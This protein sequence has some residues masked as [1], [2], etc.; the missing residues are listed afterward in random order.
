MSSIAISLAFAAKAAMAMVLYPL[1]KKPLQKVTDKL[2]KL[3]HHTSEEQIEEIYKAQRK[4][5]VVSEEQVFAVF[6]SANPELGNYIK[7]HFG[8]G[9]EELSAADKESL[10]KVIGEKLDVPK[11]TDD[12]N[13]NRVKATELAFVVEGKMSGVLPKEGDSP[14]QSVLM[15]I[16][17]KLHGTGHREEDHSP[18]KHGFIE[19]VVR[20]PR[21]HMSHV[22]RLEESRAA[23]QALIQR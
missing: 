3:D 18:V 1:A 7:Q 6:V 9:F 13:H 2:F 19:R 14:K 8:N 16:K 4:G 21:E 23:E 10:T 20:V 15:T 17:Q 12:I 11:I 22:Q 5:R